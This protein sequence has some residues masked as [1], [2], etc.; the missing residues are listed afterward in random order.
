LSLWNRFLDLYLYVRIH[1]IGGSLVIDVQRVAIAGI[2]L[3]F[4]A[5]SGNI[6]GSGSNGADPSAS[7]SGSGP[8]GGGNGGS[9]GSAGGVGVTETAVCTTPEQSFSWEV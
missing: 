6:S 7:G 5:C 9:G 4:L 1:T 8:P 2:A 3:V